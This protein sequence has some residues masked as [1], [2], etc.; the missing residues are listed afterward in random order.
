MSASR[1]GRLLLVEDES[2]LRN[3]IARFLH[4]EGYEVLEAEDGRQGVDR[5][6]EAGP[7]DLV[8]VDLDLPKL[9]GVEVCR[10][11]KGTAPAQSIL[12]CSAAILDPHFAAL[13]ELE[14]DRI[15]TKPYLP[16][17]LLSEVCSAVRPSSRA[18][19]S[20]IAADP[21]ARDSRWSSA[22]AHSQGPVP[23]AHSLVKSTQSK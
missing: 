13:D 12:V 11:I 22:P 16:A 18:I 15:L 4:I 8:I 17:R 1:H 7:F 3:L 2:R 6:R 23:H 19:A 5:F 20:P 9:T 21:T 14:I 10:Q